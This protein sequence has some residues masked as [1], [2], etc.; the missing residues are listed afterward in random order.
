MKLSTAYS[1]LKE[2][3]ISK[4]KQ[5]ISIIVSIDKTKHADERQFRHGVDEVITDNDIIDTAKKASPTL[6]KLLLFDKID[7]EDELVIYDRRND[8]NI[9]CAL[10]NP[11]R[12]VIELVIVTVMTK[13]DFKP[14]SGT[15]KIV[16]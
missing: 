7:I 15:K 6:T 16:I 12:D 1:N 5:D 14:K 11:S 2:S 10:K 8:L 9:I 3:V 4:F 13:R